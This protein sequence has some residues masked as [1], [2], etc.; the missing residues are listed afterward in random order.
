ME[1]LDVVEDVGPGV[2][3]GQVPAAVD[4]LALE[5]AEE[6]LGRSVVTAVADVAH[7]QREVVVLQEL[8]L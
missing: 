2:D 5:Y 6:P 7:A 4:P 8:L 3:H 1:A